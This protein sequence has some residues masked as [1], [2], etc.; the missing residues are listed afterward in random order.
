M[1]YVKSIKIHFLVYYSKKKLTIPLMG[2]FSYSGQLLLKISIPK[3]K[4][5]TFMLIGL[6]NVCSE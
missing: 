5:N 6:S 4:H 1:L 3:F 2:Y